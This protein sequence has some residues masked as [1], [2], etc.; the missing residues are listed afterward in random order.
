[1]KLT[2]SFY[3][4]TQKNFQ[5][6]IKKT[7]TKPRWFWNTQVLSSNERQRKDHS[8]YQLLVIVEGYIRGSF[9]NGYILLT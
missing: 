5:S 6:K 4:K 9:K 2:T 1:M 3:E 8:G 7:K